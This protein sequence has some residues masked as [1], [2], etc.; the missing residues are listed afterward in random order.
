[1][2]GDENDEQLLSR[3]SYKPGYSRKT[4]ITFNFSTDVSACYLKKLAHLA[5]MH[6]VAEFLLLAQEH[7]NFSEE[8]CQSVA[9]QACSKYLSEKSPI[10]N[11]STLQK[12]RLCDLTISLNTADSSFTQQ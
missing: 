4:R 7:C 9:K 11:F 5:R 10:Q 1:M 3:H 2:E 6:T 8:C 12:N